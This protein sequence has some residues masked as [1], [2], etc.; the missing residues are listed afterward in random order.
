M[1]RQA[2]LRGWASLR[3]SMA[4]QQQAVAAAS[5][6]T[7]GF[8]VEGPIEVEVRFPFGFGWEEGTTTV[9][10]PPAVSPLAPLA[11]APQ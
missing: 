4:Q 2:S 3:A 11:R 1:L 8:A 6:Q 10:P 9:L 7:R 5:S